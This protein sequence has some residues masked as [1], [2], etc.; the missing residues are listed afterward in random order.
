MIG[1]I[2]M[3]D[4]P[5]LERRLRRGHRH[6]GGVGRALMALKQ[7]MEL[8]EQHV[9]VLPCVARSATARDLAIRSN[10]DEPQANEHGLQRALGGQPCQMARGLS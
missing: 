4:K 2:S 9:D 3:I 10:G 6:E 1:D 8:P 7:G 5:I